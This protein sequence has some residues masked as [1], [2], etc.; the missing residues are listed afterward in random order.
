MFEL[1]PNGARSRSPQ[2]SELRVV[3]EPDIPPA[4]PTDLR[5]DPG[6]SAIRLMWNSVNEAD[7]S[8]YLVYYGEAPGNYHGQDA[9]LGPSPIDVGNVTRVDLAGLTNGKLYYIAVVAYDSTTPPHR[10]LFSTEISTRPSP[11]VGP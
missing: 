7:I 3:Y 9:E 11:L 2:V 5:A 8:G 1:F 6:N 10:S 4:P